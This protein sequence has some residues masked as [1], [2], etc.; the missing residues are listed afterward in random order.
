MI[1]KLIDDVNKSLDAESYFSALSLVLTLPDICGKAHYPN[2]KRV[3]IRY[4]RWFDEYIGKYEQCPCKHCKD[5]EM[6]YLSGEVVYSLR[7]SL[8]HQGTPN[9]ESNKIKCESN[10][11]DYFKII[12]E[13]KNEFNIYSDS[14][15]VMNGSV[16]T[17]SVNLRRLCLIICSC[18]KAYYES[19]HSKFDFFNY[20]I[21][22]KSNEIRNCE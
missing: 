21:I 18:T 9:I 6:P 2:E 19:N 4:T 15:S 13:P 16:K 1:L 17:Y 22:D 20:S 7:N 10:R 3:G 8:L 14:S 5:N 12:I 11:I